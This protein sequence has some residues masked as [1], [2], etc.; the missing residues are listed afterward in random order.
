MSKWEKLEGKKETSLT[1]LVEHS[2]YAIPLEVT[3][4]PVWKDDVKISL[5]R[6]SGLAHNGTYWG[7]MLNDKPHGIGRFV[8]DQAEIWEGQFKDG[9]MHGFIRNIYN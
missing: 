8:N 3:D 4:L 9:K 2:E 5:D 6:F 1:W 7:Q